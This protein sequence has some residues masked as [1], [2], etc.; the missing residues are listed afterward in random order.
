MTQTPL[1]L[2]LN[3][4]PISIFSNKANYVKNLILLSKTSFKKALFVSLFLLLGTI[5]EANTSQEDPTTFTNFLANRKESFYQ[6]KAFYTYQLASQEGMILASTIGTPGLA[7]N[8]ITPPLNATSGFKI[9]A[10]SSLF[11]D[12]WSITGN[13]QWFYNNALLKRSQLIGGLLYTSNFSNTT[14]TYNQ[15][16]SQFNNQFNRIDLSLERAIYTGHYVSFTANAGLLA[17]WENQYL[18][19]NLTKNTPPNT[20]HKNRLQQ[21]WWAI[22]PYVGTYADYYYTS[23]WASFLQAGTSLLLAQHKVIQLSSSNQYNS[24]NQFSNVEPMLDLSIG[25]FYENYLNDAKIRIDLGWQVQTYF[26]HNGI[27]GYNGPMGIMGN[28]SLQGL[29]A[30]IHCSF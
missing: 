10:S 17:S 9:G 24:T 4:F 5:L 8:F 29:V 18:N 25:F 7:G 6:V 15:L 30:G 20:V 2:T 27:L 19:F 11:H 28:Y 3:F 23:N 26:S 16:Y 12:D 1:S 14:T 13:Y 21:Q 22:G